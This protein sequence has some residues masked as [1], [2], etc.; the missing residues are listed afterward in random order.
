MTIKVDQL[1]ALKCK[2]ND[3]EQSI[4]KLWDNIELPNTHVAGTPERGERERDIS[5]S[6]HFIP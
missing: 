4:C 6:T 1:L 3:P 5:Q 2:E